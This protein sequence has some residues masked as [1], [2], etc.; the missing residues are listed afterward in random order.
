MKKGQLTTL[1]SFVE[2]VFYIMSMVGYLMFSDTVTTI[3]DY[4]FY[5]S[6]SKNV[7]INTINPNVAL[8]V[9]GTFRATGPAIF[10]STVKIGS[11]TLT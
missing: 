11:A 7:G 4:L 1:A 2:A 9:A 6:P 5:V 10:G 8:D 3:L